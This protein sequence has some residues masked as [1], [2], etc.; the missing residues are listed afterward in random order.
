LML[1]HVIYNIYPTDIGT[2]NVSFDLNVY[3]H[4]FGN[5]KAQRA[6]YRIL[7]KMRQL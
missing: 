6:Q 1:N 7:D 3:R 5:C 2:T 4:G